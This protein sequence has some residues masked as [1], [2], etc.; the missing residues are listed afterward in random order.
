[1]DPSPDVVSE[2]EGVREL[3]LLLTA[4]TGVTRVM[5]NL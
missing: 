2:Y 1:M 3:V 4:E 5:F